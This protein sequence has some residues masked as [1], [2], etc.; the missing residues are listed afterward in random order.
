MRLTVSDKGPGIPPDELPHIF[1]KFYR[2]S[3]GAGA[4]GT[5]L[6]LSIVKAMVEL[7]GGTVTVRSGPDGTVFAVE[8]PVADEPPD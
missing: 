1:E 8:L 6:G 4:R 2:G 5:G 7:C 3:T